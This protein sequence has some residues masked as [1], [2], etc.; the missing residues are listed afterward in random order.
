MARTETEQLVV[1]LEARVRDFEKNMAKGA[2]TA[3]RQFKK[4]NT[5]AKKSAQSLESDMKQAAARVN[6]ALAKIGLG[7]I[8]AGGFAGVI[9][10][11]KQTVSAVADIGIA[12]KQAGLDVKS[13]QELAY[14]ARVNKIEVDSL[15]AGMR[16][17]SIRG[18]EFFSTGG[19]SAA[20]AF[21]QLGF[22]A[23]DVAEK[24]KRP[25]A[26]LSEIIGKVQKLDK[27][28]QIRIFDELF[29]G[30]G[31]RFVR[32]IDQGERGIRDTITAANDLGVVL[33]E[34]LI[35]K[36]DE[37]DRAFRTVAGTVSTYLQGAIIRAADQLWSFIELFQGWDK[38]RAGSVDDRLAALG[39][40]RLNTEN[41]ILKTQ[42][43]QRQSTGLNP[44]G[45]DFEG[46]L[47][48]ARQRLSEIADE[49]QRI[50]AARKG[51]DDLK[52]PEASNL[53][54]PSIVGDDKGSKSRD[55]AAAA[56][57]RE[58]DAV[59]KLIEE[60]EFE[61]SL[62]GMSEKQRRAAEAGRKAGAAAT[63]AQ[64]QKIIALTEAIHQEQAAMDAAKEKAEKWN[65]TLEAGFGMVGDALSDIAD[66]SVKAEDAIKRL[67]VQLALAAAQGALLGSGPLAG[68]FGGGG[69]FGGKTTAAVDPWAGMRVPGFAKGTNNAP[70]GLAVVGEKGPELINLPKGSQVFPK[71]P[72]ALPASGGNVS[73]SFSPV[74]DARGADIAAVERLE[75]GLAKVNQEFGARVVTTVRMAQKTR[76]L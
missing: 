23:A 11:A 19:G 41:Q 76:N 68:L 4:I 51:I 18:S 64:R 27:A 49:E 28:S 20:E 30:D 29:G 73:M 6:G 26:F 65:Q 67:A 66:G 47:I 16:E 62:L 50:L 34:R 45:E 74:I 63:E 31:E 13:F 59:R 33:D 40:E 5:S 10:T 55:K 3:D 48:E 17:L 24:L 54:A 75:R 32:L 71:V 58:A 37:L 56:A 8:A 53:V 60:L 36:A 69:L 1:K 44:F 2:N 14:V 9:A 25:S 21:K 35:K 38:A 15:A 22:S 52:K 70:G 61:Y 43:R 72:A 46:G 39:K 12:A 7:G 57:Q 42:E